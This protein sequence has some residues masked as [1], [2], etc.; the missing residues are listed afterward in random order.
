[1][2]ESD[3]IAKLKSVGIDFDSKSK[4]DELESLL[5]E[6]PQET[7]SNNET[8]AKNPRLAKRSKSVV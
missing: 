6:R 7:E 1:M 4:K 8:K 3:I 5:V 2:K